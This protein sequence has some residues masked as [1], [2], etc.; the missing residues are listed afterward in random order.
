M[1]DPG[2]QSAW[3]KNCGKGFFFLLVDTILCCYFMLFFHYIGGKNLA[4]K[5]IWNSCVSAANCNL[6]PCI[7]NHQS[8]FI[9]LLQ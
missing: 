8:K 7:R 1:I 3:P 2:M 4:T 6:T 5:T 9:H